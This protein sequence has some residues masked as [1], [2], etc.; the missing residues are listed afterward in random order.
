MSRRAAGSF[1]HRLC[2]NGFT[3][4]EVLVVVAII[5]LLISIL[6]PSLKAAR[7][8]AKKVTCGT[9]LHQ[10]GT[11]LTSYVTDNR[12]EL[13]VRY[14]TASSFTTYFMRAGLVHKGAVGLGLLA[15]RRY[16]PEPLVF[17]CPG[18]DNTKSACLVYNSVDNRWVTDAAF[19]GMTDSAK[20]D[21]KVRASYMA[22]PGMK[23]KYAQIGAK[24][25]EVLIPSGEV[26]GWRQDEYY[27]KVIYSDFL[28]VHGF[29]NLA[30]DSTLINSPHDRKGYYRLFGDMSAR[31]KHAAALERLRRI[32]EE[33]PDGPEMIAYWKELDR[34]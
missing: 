28:G 5:A 22:R 17:Y 10:I 30:V 31:W 15:N 25:K 8:E 18:Q 7:D 4:I 9:N 20:R 26:V 6:L 11:G 12:G 16:V 24:P 19:S 3:L 23:E 34:N 33:P 13:P 29:F 14:R 2:V 21:V 1:T 27:Q 32:N